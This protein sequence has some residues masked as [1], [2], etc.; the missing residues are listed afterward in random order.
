VF[1][2][3]AGDTLDIGRK[4]RAIPPAMRRALDNRDQG[5]R[6]PG[7]TCST[8]FTD[9]HHIHHWADGGDTKLQNLALLCRHHHRLVHEGGFSVER[10]GDELFFKRPDG[11]EI[12]PVPVVKPLENAG[13]ETIQ[14]K[15]AQ[16]GLAIDARTAVPGWGGET[17]DY[18]YILTMLEQ[19]E[20]R[21]RRDGVG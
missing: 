19:R 11:R 13:A 10:R 18:T 4:T 2:N 5:C 14:R 3:A 9:A 16:A 1:E 21:G 15:H 6:F 7:C 17:P 8:R 12:P 20:A